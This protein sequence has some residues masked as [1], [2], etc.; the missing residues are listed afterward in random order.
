MGSRSLEL[1]SLDDVRERWRKVVGNRRA[2]V[3]LGVAMAVVV[4]GRAWFIAE[5][6]ELQDLGAYRRGAWGLWHLGDPYADAARGSLLPFIYPTFAAIVF[7]PLIALPVVGMRFAV[8][9]I[10]MALLFACVRLV[11]RHGVQVREPHLL[12]VSAVVWLVVLPSEPVFATIGLGQVNVVLL[13]MVLVDVVAWRDRRWSGVLVGLAVGMK[14][15]PAIFVV[16]LATRGRW[17]AVRNAVAA[18]ASTVVVSLVIAPTPT[19]RYFVDGEFLFSLTEVAK[20]ANQSLNGAFH[21]MWGDGAPAR[22]AWVVA[23]AVVAPAGLWAASRI[24]RREGECAGVA[25][26]ALVGLLVAPSSWTHYWIWWV[27]LELVAV[28]G[29]RRGSTPALVGAVLWPVPFFAGAWWFPPYPERPELGRGVGAMAMDRMYVVAGMAAW[30]CCV[31]VAV[32]ERRSA[33]S[34]P[35][36]GGTRRW[37]RVPWSP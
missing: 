10:S 30:A 3:A 11:L 31:A 13:A 28:A 32:R 6:W 23:V 16:Y 26:A 19:W 34:T 37:W 5:H 33:I 36:P 20:S 1:G 29:A 35:P 22:V 18:A 2:R 24:A 17:P 9:A 8:T 15:T 14:L 12:W 4:V 27:V 21:D 25:V 7:L